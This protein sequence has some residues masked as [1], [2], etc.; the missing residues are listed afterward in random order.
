MKFCRLNALSKRLSCWYSSAV[1]EYPAVNRYDG[2]LTNSMRAGLKPVMKSDCRL[3]LFRR[4]LSLYSSE[5]A[6]EGNSVNG[7]RW[8]VGARSPNSSSGHDPSGTL[9]LGRAG[10]EGAGGCSVAAPTGGCWPHAGRAITQTA[11]LATTA[12][13]TG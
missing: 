11:V 10:G 8:A 9:G 5:T 3:L 13:P 12:G 1:D 4:R 6:I 2:R 7:P